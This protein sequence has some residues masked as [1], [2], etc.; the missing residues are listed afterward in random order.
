MTAGAAAGSL[1]RASPL[2]RVLSVR[3]PVLWE[4]AFYAVVFAS[5]FGLRFWDLG[6]RAL[7][8][9]ESIHAQWSWNL[10]DYNHSPVF[11]GPFY[12]HVQGAVFFLFGSSDYTSRISPALF[13]L[14]IVV[15]PLLLRRR[16]GVVGTAATVC[17]L[18][19]SPT[20]VYYSRFMREDIFMAFFVLLMAVSMWRYIEEG[21]ER[22]LVFFA[23]GFTGAM[24]SK[25]GAF[26]VVAAFLVFLDVYV[27]AQLARQT[28][29]VRDLNTTP[30]R[31]VLTGALTPWA[32]AVAGLWPFLG[33]IRRRMDWD[34][35]LPRPADVL[36][37]LMTFTFVLLTPVA[38]PYF[39]EPLGILE[40]DRLNWQQNLQGRIPTDDAMALAGIFAMTISIA[41][42]VGLQ[43]RARLWAILFAGCGFIYLTL[44]TSFWT[45]MDGLVS[46]P[47][48]SLDYW[49]T[50][51]D[52]FRGDQPWFYYYLLMPAYEFLPLIICIGGAWWSMVRGD[53]FSRFLWVWL[54]GTWAGLSWGSEKMPWLNTHLALPAC[55]LAGWTVART[56]R[57]WRDRPG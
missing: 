55:L 4:S 53:A 11:H 45:N 17:F 42:F 12:Y 28:L 25:E 23:L 8:H 33:N 49:L 43:W 41:A 32:W 34:E 16:L 56:W 22:W 31:F 44:M 26:L 47:W 24:S 2:E 27:A 19:F 14:G 48:G 57:A 20:L 9:D 15:L 38:R 54:I 39:L 29:A 3:V 46:G 13:G 30:R 5:A 35:D 21:R 6:T 52:E 51:Q 50:Q 18:A 37:L 40:E 7:H 10:L 36:I 1:Y